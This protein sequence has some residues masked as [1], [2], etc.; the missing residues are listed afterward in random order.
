MSGAQ[1]ENDAALV[2]GSGVA[3]LRAAL[4]LADAGFQ[5]YIVESGAAVG[6]TISQLDKQFPTDDCGLCKMLP[7]CGPQAPDQ[8]CLRRGIR[9]PR[10]ELI[11]NAQVEKVDGTAG[12]FQ[13]SLRQKNP[14]V[15]PQDC[16]GCGLCVP[17]CPVDVPGDSRQTIPSRK[18][19]FLP[20]PL[21][22]PLTYT[23]DS[24]TC[25]RCGACVEI[26][27]TR[28]IDLNRGDRVRQLQVGSVILASGFQ[29]FDPALLSAYGHSRYPNVITSI[30]LER[31]FSALGP[32]GGQLGSFVAEK[33]PGR[34]AF[35]QCVG[36]RDEDREYCSSACCMYALKEAAQ[37]RDF[38]PQ[39]KLDFFYMDLRACGKGYHRYYQRIQNDPGVHFIR[40][41]VPSVEGEPGGPDL[42]IRYETEG[43]ELI[44]DEYQLIV[45]SIG[46]VAPAQAKQLAESLGIQLDRYGFCRGD[47]LSGVRTS[48]KGIYVCGSFSG[49]RDIPESVNQASAAALM[50]ATH[51]DRHQAPVGSSSAEGKA[52]NAPAKIGIFFCTCAKQLEEGFRLEEVLEYAGGLP[53]VILTQKLDTLCLPADL[54]QVKKAVREKALNRIVVAACSPTLFS[55]LF[56][57]TVQEAG[58]DPALLEQANLREQLSWIHSDKERATEK[59]KVLVR[60]AVERARWQRPRAGHA[61]Q[62]V[63]RA[64]VVGGGA[65][66]LSCSWAIA[67]R[68]FE[69]DLVEKESRTGGHLRHIHRTLEGL[70]GQKVLADMLHKV[71]S[72]DKIRIYTETQ[73]VRVSGGMGHFHV[74]LKSK[75]STP[76]S[77][78]HGVIV[79]ATGAGEVQTQEYLAGQDERVID[80]KELAR[81]LAA[82]DPSISDMKAV[83]MIQC[84][85]S[86]DDQRLYCSK[87]CCSKAIENSLKLKEV[88]P[89]VQIFVL[90]RDIMTY[91]FKEEYYLE[92]RQKGVNFLH[93]D[94]QSKPSVSSLDDKLEVVV[95]DQLLDKDLSI[96]ADL[97]VLSTGIDPE[98]PQLFWEQL[99]LPRTADGFLQEMNVKFQP[100]EF[101]RPG[102]FLCGLAHSAKPLVESITQAHGVASRAA[103]VLSKER[104]SPV[105]NFS[106]V[107]EETCDG[108]GICISTCEYEAIQLLRVDSDSQRAH[109]N[110]NLCRGCG[111]C[112]VAC[113]CGAIE[114]TGYW[115]DQTLATI[116]AALS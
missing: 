87:F 9:H 97:L 93:Y 15:S 29:E 83:V 109:I 74:Q 79:V 65:A 35:I 103:A 115:R 96:S 7:A 61:D 34:I 45:L 12:D 114:Q 81:R 63:P 71:E 33:P 60:M 94:L 30:E 105:R 28:A 76:L 13:V 32:T 107:D 98:I 77:A 85:G 92:A 57:N 46:Q 26:C 53:H 70:D 18:A 67:Q 52:E 16:I 6:G 64:L 58:L 3:G 2:V 8:F 14:F 38:Y 23:I 5:V 73:V 91:G 39:A 108:C 78:E 25:T 10:V 27:P 104:L 90:Y 44:S 99:H 101:A 36:S 84:V 75:G 22:V 54:A 112:V 106:R 48:R 19:I 43:G 1:R 95:A 40:C 80:Q 21:S 37:L 55:N 20:H 110:E 88:N 62:V 113:P 56:E 51:L 102:I 4:D 72:S 100:V 82:G 69:V 59:A 24:E 31:M 47:G 41:R 50:A 66:G 17:V 68:G 49:P 42:R 89:Q 11:L 116:R 111:C 86:R